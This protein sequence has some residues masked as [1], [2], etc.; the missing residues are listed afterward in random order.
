MTNVEKL[1]RRERQILEL[2]TK[3]LLSKQIAAE[4]KISY[5]T[6]RIHRSNILKKLNANSTAHAVAMLYE[7]KIKKGELEVE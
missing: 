1:T 5:K 4:L 3:G 2:T 7:Y 6:V